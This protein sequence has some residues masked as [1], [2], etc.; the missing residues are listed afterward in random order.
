MG[1]GIATILVS[2]KGQQ[3]LHTACLEFP[4]TNNVIE[5]EAL[6]LVLHKTKAL[7]AQRIV[8]K[9]DYHLMAGHIDMSLQARDS[10]MTRYLAAVWVLVKHFLGIPV[11]ATPHGKN[12]ATDEPTKMASSAQPP[13]TNVFYEVFKIPSAPA[14]HKGLGPKLKGL[15]PK[16]SS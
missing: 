9:S 3:I 1:A 8:V 7:G 10:E 16:S 12:V 6:L 13:P 5:Y 4:S 11:Q 2:P 15:G 14:E